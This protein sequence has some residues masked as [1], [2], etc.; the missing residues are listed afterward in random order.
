MGLFD[1]EPKRN[2]ADM[3]FSLRGHRCLIPIVLADQMT[4]SDFEV[5]LTSL[6]LM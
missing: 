3:A 4:D 1:L 2:E 5:N 6:R